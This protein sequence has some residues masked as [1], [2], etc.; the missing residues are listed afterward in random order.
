MGHADFRAGGRVFASLGPKGD[1]AMVKL[2]PDE[3]EVL[4]AEAPEVYERFGG[5]WGRSGCTRIHLRS[6][7]KGEVRRLLALA[8]REA[9][10]RRRR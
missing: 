10:G 7:R 3:Q 9:A 4:V 6:A 1:W 5:A 2:P 8:N